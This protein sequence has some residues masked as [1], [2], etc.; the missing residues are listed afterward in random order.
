MSK[1]KCVFTF[2][3]FLIIT[4]YKS[5]EY[6]LY[7]PLAIS[8]PPSQRLGAAIYHYQ[9]TPIN[10]ILSTDTTVVTMGNILPT[11]TNAQVDEYLNAVQ[12]MNDNNILVYITLFGSI[13]GSCEM[14]QSEWHDYFPDTW[15]ERKRWLNRYNYLI[16]EIRSKDLDVRIQVWNEADYSSGMEG[17]FGCGP[18]HGIYLKRLVRDVKQRWTDQYILTSFALENTSESKTFIDQFLNYGGDSFTDEITMHSYGYWWGSGNP[19]DYLCSTTWGCPENALEWLRERTDDSVTVTEYNLLCDDSDYWSCD[20][21]YFN[22]QADYIEQVTHMFFN[23]GVNVCIVYAVRSGWRH[24]NILDNPPI[25]V[26][27]TYISLA[28]HYHHSRVP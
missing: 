19:D 1:T 2:F 10:F 13:S 12:L 17:A 8:S 15:V 24:A 3:C 9:D 20:D 28:K 21:D 26:E 5:T 16:S 22:A 27:D 25:P 14:P 6:K 11:W 4:S 7:I 18:S 23:H